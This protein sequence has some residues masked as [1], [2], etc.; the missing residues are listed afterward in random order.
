VLLTL[1]GTGPLF[2]QIYRSV[3]DAILSGRVRTGERLPASRTL[4]RELGVSRNVVLIA[5][6]QLIAEGYATGRTGAGTYVAASASQR[7]RGTS[8]GS[9]AAPRLSRYATRLLSDPA[10]DAPLAGP[11][12]RARFDFS[13]YLANPEDFP[14]ATWRRLLARHLRTLPLDYTAAGG[15]LILRRE[16]ARYLVRTRGIQCES[17][18]VLLVNGSQQALDLV[19]RV[20]LD[21]GDRVVMEDP[22]YPG[23]REV[24]RAVGGRVIPVAVDGYGLCV[25]RLPRQARLAYVT[26]SHQFPTGAV[27]PLERRLALLAWAASRDVYVLE[28]DYGGEYRYEGRP[29]EAVQALDRAGR[30]LYTGTF[31]RILFPS[32]RVGYL[33]APP[34]LARALAQSKWVSDRHTSLLQQAALA[35]FLREGHLDRAVRRARQRHARSR[36]TLLRAIGR[37]FGGEA[38]VLGAEAGVHVLIRFPGVRPEVA[39]ECVA[40]ACRAGVRVG[41]VGHYYLSGPRYCEF[42]LGYAAMNPPEIAAGVRILA[43][44]LRPLSGVVCRACSAV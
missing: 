1:T 22:H 16:I 8:A 15:D 19:A 41:P 29:I 27:L 34:S 7:P 32:L 35:D 3:R 5:Y 20:L 28:D 10:A 39:D 13:Y 4:A 2:Q 33:V 26:P 42:M 17:E 31:S 36:D 14:A 23:A 24:F 6:E 38:E 9:R 11:P 43:T 44:A 18:D 40:A 25:D 30:V 37:N 12:Q 21:P